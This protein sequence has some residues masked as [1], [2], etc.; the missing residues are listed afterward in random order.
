VSW[1]WVVALALVVAVV[2]TGVWAVWFSS[3]LAVHDVEV[4]GTTTVS[5]A[6]V[7]RLSGIDDG[8]PLARV[9]L[10]RARQRVESLAQVRSVD[11]TRHWPHTVR[12]TVHE[13]VPVAVVSVGGR[14][15]ALDEDGVLFDDYR[16]PP[17]GLPRVVTQTGM[18]TAALREAAEVVT[19]LPNRL[20]VLVDHVSLQGVGQVQLA[21]RDGRTAVWGDATQSAAKASVLLSLLATPATS[22]D[23][24]VPS[25]PVVH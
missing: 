17:A 24:S 5:S 18:T 2:A 4:S 15:R 13:R 22:Y 19:A 9:D 21:L 1:R 6:E 8:T 3:L 20:S 16:R 7:R 11:V 10:S 23:V 25:R 14:L 12:I